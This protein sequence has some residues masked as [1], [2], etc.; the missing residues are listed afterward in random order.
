MVNIED[1]MQSCLM[2]GSALIAM[3]C[4]SKYIGLLLMYYRTLL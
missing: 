4:L 1:P 3:D 2:S